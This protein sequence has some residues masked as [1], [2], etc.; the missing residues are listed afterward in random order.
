MRKG[1]TDRP[2]KAGMRRGGTERKAGMGRGGTGRGKQGR[3]QERKGRRGEI[4]HWPE[5]LS[6]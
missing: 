4:N 2:R 5:V 1:G 3:R 6:L